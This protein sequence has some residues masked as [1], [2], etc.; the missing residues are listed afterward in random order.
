MVGVLRDIGVV[1]D[2]PP[3]NTYEVAAGDVE[4]LFVP[5]EPRPRCAPASSCSGRSWRASGA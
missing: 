5:L 4:W 3:P 2:H 1:V